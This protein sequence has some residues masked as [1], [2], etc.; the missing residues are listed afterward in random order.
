MFTNLKLTA[1]MML[2]IGIVTAI[3]FTLTI[4]I[5]SI[6]A[7]NMAENEGLSKVQEI[8]NRYSN[9][10]KAEIEVSLDTVRTL[11]QTFEGMRTS[12]T[13]DR[14]MMDSILKNV[15]EKDTRFT[16]VWTLWEP[17]ALDGRDSEF[18]DTPGHDNTGRYLPYWNRGNGS[19]GVEA[20]VDYETGDFYNVP[21]N[22][23]QETV[24]EPYK[25]PISGKEVLM[26]SIVV[27]I[28]YEGEF[29]GVAGIDVILDTLQKKV[30]TIKPYETGYSSLISNDGIYVADIKEENIFSSIT[31]E[32]AKAAIKSGE[33]YTYSGYSEILGEKV[34]TVYIPIN[35]GNTK[36]P[37]SLAVT[38]PMSKVLQKAV[39][40]RN[41]SIIFGIIALIVLMAV[42]YFIT[43][44]IVRPIKELTSVAEQIAE[45]NLSTDIKVL[46]N[47]DEV[48][49]LSRAFSKM[50]LNLKS[51]AVMAER[52]AQGDLN[53]N[54]LLD[55]SIKSGDLTRAF[56]KMLSN[57]KLLMKEIDTL[58]HSVEEGNLSVRGNP[59]SFSGGW[60][61]LV[62]G[63]NKLIDTFVQPINVTA[64]H[65][66]RI[67]K[68]DIPEKLTDK[69]NGDFNEIKNSLNACIDAI[70]ALVADANMLAESAIEGKLETRA[71]TTRH[72][73]D[74]RKI[75]QGVNRTLDAVIE[76]I[77]ESS[78]VLQQMAKGNM[79]VYVKG[80]YKGEHAVIKESLNLTIDH[81]NEILWE[82]NE[83]AQQV[84]AG[85]R[86]VAASSQ[87]LSQGATE[88][89]SAIEEVT[90]SMTQVS[91][92]TKQNAINAN[93]ASE[94][95]LT[96]KDNAVQGKNQMEDML[97]SM[98]EIN[99]ASSNIS[100]IIKVIDEI[101]FQTNILA[102]N[103]AVEAARAGQHGK[104]FAVVAEE[105]RNLAERSAKAARETTEMI[106][107]S[108]KKV[109]TGTKIAN[110]TSE[111]LNK[112]VDG[113]S[114]ASKL[115]EEI[116]AASNEQATGISQVNQAISQVA[117]VLHT[118][119]V[120][121]EESASANEELSNQANLLKSSLSRFT[122]K[123][124]FV[125]EI[126]P[127]N[128]N[129]K[130]I[131][132]IENLLDEKSNPHNEVEEP[133]KSVDKKA[134]SKSKIV[135]VD[136]E[137]GKY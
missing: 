135:L 58:I 109:E 97:V 25:Y 42:I 26:S 136:T 54:G 40:I 105:V 84:A 8:T 130:T 45:D 126:R 125:E 92:Q 27:P 103:A 31:D 93:Q 70:K 102:L 99:S 112:I 46:K 89:A 24:T 115:S 98:Q 16:G 68:G 9:E 90:S 48:G 13:P 65:V 67:S 7:F 62:A 134:S 50:Q 118:N 107:G 88:Q 66:E 123:E 12:G 121:A 124:H 11:A 73:G 38:V 132:M 72:E 128:A 95:A 74:F 78:M 77:K 57:L 23:G 111:A 51:M 43:R 81:I 33:V 30:E 28:N 119:S 82:V 61:Q 110:D 17:D 4:T 113:V 60:S 85:S 96:V 131:R 37:W 129:S 71:D 108:I 75:V 3:A 44:S 114:R 91:A 49:D 15:L 64:Q 120:G 94:L 18:A 86:Q 106:E 41:F 100:R 133:C 36:T 53:D 56:S 101:A 87:S 76:P 69:Y 2:L 52:I 122:L 47:R 5:S 22:T 104:G 35:M 80:S 14:K 6:M 79:D 10:V 117:E 32:K 1:K 137:F 55:G 116:A 63:I 19:I 59:G 29:M 83:S 21:K 20:I 34:Y 39:E 127:K